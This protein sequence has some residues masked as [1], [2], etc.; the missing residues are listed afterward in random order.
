MSIR[1][2]GSLLSSSAAITSANTATG[3]W[4]SN[5]IMQ[6]LFTSAWP[7][8]PVAGYNVIYPFTAS[9]SWTVP[10]GVTS[11]DYLIVAGGGGGTG[12]VGAGGRTAGGGAGG[13]RTV[14][15]FSVTPGAT[16]PITVG[17]GGS[18][19][20][21]Y[22]NLAGKGSNSQLFISNSYSFNG[23]SQYLTAPTSSNW[24]FSTDNFTIE[25]WVYF[26]GGLSSAQMIVTTNYNA[27]T[28]AGGWALIY[29]GDI[30]SLQL[31]VNSNVT[32]TKSWTPSLNVWYHVAVSR[33]G[34]DLKF[35]INGTQIGTTSTS[36][37]N[38]ANA[39]TLVVGNNLGGTPNL[40]LNGNISN[41]RIVTGVAVYTGNFT[42]PITSLTATQIAGTNINAT[43]GTQ[44]S[45]LLSGASLTDSS[46]NAFT[47]TNN[48]NITFSNIG[49]F[50]ISATGGGYGSN[51][52]D[53][54]GIGGSGGGASYTGRTLG[55]GNQ[56]GYSPVEGYAGG[57]GTNNSGGG[58]GGAGAVGNDGVGVG[59]ANGGI[60]R[61]SSITGTATYY[62]GGGGS[63]IWTGI[64]PA[65]VGGLGGGG[66]G[67]IS[68]AGGTSGTTNTGGGGGSSST[69]SSAGGGAG[70]SGI[71]ILAYTV[72]VNTVFTF[73]AS[74]TFRTPTTAATADYLVVAGGG[75]NGRESYSTGA[76]GGG[77]AGGLLSGTS[78][79][80]A[81]NTTYTV[82]VGAGGA[83]FVGSGS[84]GGGG[85]NG[86][87]SQVL[88]SNSY[89]FNGSSQYLTVAASSTLAL[90]GDFTIEAWVYLASGATYQFLM[91]SS[92]S[93]G[94]MIGFNVSNS[95]TQ[96]IA[97]GNHNVAWLLNFGSSISIV[98]NTWTHVAITR[99]GSTNRAFINGVQLGSNITDTTSWAFTNNS[100]YIGYHAG[101]FLNGNISNLRVV[102]GVAAYTGNFTV[103]TLPLT[104]TQNAGTN[105]NA[106]TG[107]QTSLLLSGAS[108]TD[109]STN[110]LAITNT[111]TVAFS[112][113]SPFSILTIGGGGGGGGTSPG[114]VGGSGGSGG[115]SGGI[116]AGTGIA[117][118]PRQGYNGGTGAGGSGGGGA[119][120]AGSI[121][122][123][124]AGGIGLQSAISGGSIYYAG[125]GAGG[126]YSSSVTPQGG[127]GGGGNG[128]LY[129]VDQS[130][131]AG[132]A[133]TGGGAGGAT[134]QGGAGST[135]K[136]GGSG[137]VIIKLT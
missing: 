96:T 41:L 9:G 35:F 2:K 119:G 56:G 125:G 110:A 48:N 17:A 24:N 81:T 78:L 92:A 101:I 62:A 45:L 23:S 18:G 26:T 12:S 49:P 117:G 124:G 11:V 100:P 53:N 22:S 99:A 15:G 28:G 94:M 103:P 106:I 130:A 95:G 112:N 31:S 86:A 58:G 63:G 7:T 57:M 46:S 136:A 32:Y 102:T 89:S 64:G 16:Y 4:R 134:N 39:T 47:I 97:V 75:G 51:D 128:A 69:S 71:V 68:G 60:G 10:P 38:I 84:G 83:G 8:G 42:T 55:T 37:D 29:R 85:S 113:T 127:A 34:S 13:F 129:Y 65:G 3:I 108:L 137:I 93:G 133:N 66:S 21:I 44:T 74:S 19:S 123:G 77:G 116:G 122:V 27:S 25:S 1:Y 90:A 30:G 61:L 20:T 120:G 50:S 126:S 104:A 118:P 33:S 70:G 59:N 73:T 14:T 88:V 114:V 121:G 131:T 132:T 107:T 87:N 91:G 82:T 79:A 5:D 72:P 135:P 40:Y 52:G 115:G 43:T 111:G 76:G 98:T 80:L 36:S 105:I 54:A 6:A 109:S 67:G